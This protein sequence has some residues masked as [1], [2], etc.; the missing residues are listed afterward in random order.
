MGL[1]MRDRL[2]HWFDLLT[3]TKSLSFKYEALLPCWWPWLWDGG[4]SDWDHLAPPQ[5]R[6]CSC[7]SAAGRTGGDYSVSP[8]HH[9][10][11]LHRCPCPRYPDSAWQH[12]IATRTAGGYSGRKFDLSTEQNFWARRSITQV[13]LCL[14]FGFVFSES[15]LVHCS[16][17]HPNVALS[18]L[19]KSWERTTNKTNRNSAQLNNTGRADPLMFLFLRVE[20]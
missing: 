2:M 9:P 1:V 10:L 6:L 20:I 18:A 19:F 5:D 7:S 12:S 14:V 17:S 15:I 3:I 13:Y 8:P 11:S 4:P 16:C